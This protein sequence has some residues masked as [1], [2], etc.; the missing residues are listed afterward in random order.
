LPTGA[1]RT[2]VDRFWERASSQPERVALRRRAFAG[3]ESITWGDYGDAVERAS[4]GLLSLGLRPGDRMG[5]LSSNRPEWFFADLACMSIGGTTAPIYLSNSPA[6]VGHV[7]GHSGARIVVVETQDQLDKVMAVRSALPRLERVV[8]VEPSAA[9][10][11]GFVVSWAELLRSGANGGADCGGRAA[12]PLPEDIA[13]FVYTS[14][15]TGSPK[16]VMLTH[17]NIWWTCLS[18]QRHLRMEDAQNERALSYLPLSH[19]AERMVS[20][21]MQILFG[22]QT[23][24][25]PNP[26]ELADDLLACRPTYFFGVPRVWEKFH[27]V[28]QARLDSKP[29]A[30]RARV[31]VALLRRALAVGRRVSTAEQEAVAAGGRMSEAR[32]GPLLRAQHAWLERAVLSKAR[33]RAGLDRCERTFSAAAPIAE[34]IVWFFHAMGVKI[35]EGYGQ[36]ETTGPTTWNPPDGIR[37]GSVGIPIPGVTI[38]IAADGEVLVQGGNVTPG[39]HEDPDATAELLDERGLMHSGDVGTIDEYG[40]LTI[41]DRKK[42]IIITSGGKNIAP[43]EIE[44]KLKSDEIISEVVVIGDR[45]PFV[46]AL[47]TLNEEKAREWGA[48]QGIEGGVAEIAGDERTLERVQAAFDRVNQSLARVEQVKRFR[49]LERDFLQEED[50][51]TPTL[52]VKRAVVGTR[53]GRAIDGMYEPLA[54]AAGAARRDEEG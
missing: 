8:V 28:V 19:I 47:V 22:S 3:W 17:A 46:V 29:R 40:Y 5:L 30:P 20:H 45:R 33:A 44:N 37:I 24:F 50:E 48:Q 14:G 38:E 31:E 12:R 1:A 54:P 42:D 6:Q 25:A 53:Y 27:A 39:Y 16:A 13:T 35:A 4:R 49:V 52:K 18:L 7:L 51:I 41:T 21:F 23:W 43:Q 15:T 26:K 34:E 36:S 9:A 32:L 2:I 10:C 11:D